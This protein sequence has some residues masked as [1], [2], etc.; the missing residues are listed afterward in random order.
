MS[1]ILC[2]R[3]TLPMPR[4]SGAEAL[5]TKE[6]T[7]TSSAS[8]RETRSFVVPLPLSSRTCSSNSRPQ[9]PPAAL[10]IRKY[11]VDGLDVGVELAGQWTGLRGD[12]PHLHLVGRHAD[13]GGAAARRSSR[14]P[15]AASR[16]AAA[17]GRRRAPGSRPAEGL[18]GS[19]VAPDAGYRD[20]AGAA[21]VVER[22]D[23]RAACGGQQGEGA[24]ERECAQGTSG[25]THG[26]RSASYP[27]AEHPEGGGCRVPCTLKVRRRGPVTCT[28]GLSE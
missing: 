26:S 22:N 5:P 2:S 14:H 20:A 28:F 15:E 21:R 1:G 27:W 12:Q 3:E 13:V 24:R 9:T 25:A 11:G 10:I 8:S 16:P 18:P 6:K 19:V 17:D 7:L 4:S 23:A